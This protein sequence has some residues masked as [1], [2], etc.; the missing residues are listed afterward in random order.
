MPSG[1]RRAAAASCD[2][3]N[4]LFIHPSSPFETIPK[5]HNVT[6]ASRSTRSGAAIRNQAGQRLETK[7]SQM[8]TMSLGT[9]SGNANRLRAGA[10][11]IRED[12]SQAGAKI[13]HAASTAVSLAKDQIGRAAEKIADQEQCAERWITDLVQARPL[14]VLISAIGIGVLAGFL[15]RTK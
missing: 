13:S 11:E 7:M 3:R 2:P 1:M 4:S 8:S 15:L 12:L 6:A 9:D 14:T 5:S 10:S